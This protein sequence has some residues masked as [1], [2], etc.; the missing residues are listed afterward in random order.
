MGKLAP[1]INENGDASVVYCSVIKVVSLEYEDK[2]LG[3]KYRLLVNL[4]G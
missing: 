1:S 3:R 2:R 4:L